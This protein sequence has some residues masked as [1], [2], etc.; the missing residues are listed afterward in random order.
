A[1]VK[2]AVICALQAA[3]HLGGSTR[4]VELAAIGRRVCES[5][6]DLLLLLDLTPDDADG[7]DVDPGPPP[8][9]E[10]FGHPT[11][12]ELVEAVREHLEASMD[13]GG[14]RAAFDDRVARNVLLMVE[15]ELRL[16]PGIARAH[17]DRLADL[18]FEGD[19]S[20]AS[21][22]RSGAFDGDLGTV[23]RALGTSARDQLL[24]ANPPYLDAPEV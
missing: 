17:A 3:T 12:P 14:G 9:V 16:G 20:L 21:A 15:R 2:W 6:W 19:A 8:V 1:A 4:S 22:I 5:E 11:A 24:V 23:G 10:P 18:G 7:S 13:R